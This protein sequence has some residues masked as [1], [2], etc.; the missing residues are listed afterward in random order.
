MHADTK[1]L[2]WSFTG[3]YSNNEYKLTE[4]D[5]GQMESV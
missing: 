5:K 4:P 2:T 3:L 1:P